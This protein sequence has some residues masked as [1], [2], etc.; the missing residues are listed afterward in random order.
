MKNKIII[1]GMAGLLTFFTG[2]ALTDKAE[3]TEETE[4]KVNN[5]TTEETENKAMDKPTEGTTDTVTKEEI[6]EETGNETSEEITTGETGK[7]EAED[8][9]DTDGEA[10]EAENAAGSEQSVAS[11]VYGEIINQYATAVIEGHKGETLISEG[12]NIMVGEALNY[13]TSVT[14]GYQIKDINFDGTDELI[15]GV[16]S[17]DEFYDKLVIVCYTVLEEQPYMLFESGE[18]SRYY[19]CGEGKVYYEGSGSAGQSSWALCS[20]DFEL[21]YFDG[22]DYDIESNPEKPWLRY[23]DDVWVVIDEEQADQ[24][25]FELQRYRQKLELTAF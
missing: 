19:Y 13:G 6:K 20:P 5:Q 24:C 23:M 4:S 14:V 15:I 11:D 7:T 10:Q 9:E 22:V 8:R 1:L 2:C 25:I 3:T 17:A 18:R 16:D 12:L 21:R